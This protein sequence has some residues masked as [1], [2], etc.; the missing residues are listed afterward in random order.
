LEA[1]QD[2]EARARGA[3]EA[4]GGNGDGV[5]ARASARERKEE[6]GRALSE[7]GAPW[8]PCQRRRPDERGHRW[9]TGAIWRTGVALD[10]HDG[11]LGSDSGDVITD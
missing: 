3:R 6:N 7:C 5:S 8:R 9:R 4:L 2:A 10:I 11:E 1:K